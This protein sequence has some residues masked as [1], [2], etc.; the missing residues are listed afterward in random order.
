MVKRETIEMTLL[1]IGTTASVIGAMFTT[2]IATNYHKK[3]Q[4]KL[5]TCE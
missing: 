3:L 1:I 5:G 2:L 4:K